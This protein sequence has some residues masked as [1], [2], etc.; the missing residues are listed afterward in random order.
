MQALAA[1]ICTTTPEEFGEVIRQDF[2]KW[3]RMVKAAG[4]KPD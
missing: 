2:S 1:E 3:S 4:V